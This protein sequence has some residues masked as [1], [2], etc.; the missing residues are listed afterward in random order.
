MRRPGPPLTLK[1]NPALRQKITVGPTGRFVDPH[2]LYQAGRRVNQL[3]S[4]GKFGIWNNRPVRI[5][6]AV[7]YSVLW[8]Q[9]YDRP[10]KPEMMVWARDV[11]VLEAYPYRSHKYEPRDTAASEDFNPP[12]RFADPY[13]EGW[14]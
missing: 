1:F 2:T 14:W 3:F 5:T 8:I 6:G 10:D 11:D 12:E 13:E 4:L 7:N 9:F